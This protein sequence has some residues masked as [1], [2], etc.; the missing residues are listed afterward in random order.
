M[1]FKSKMLIILLVAFILIFSTTQCL[2]V[3]N[4]SIETISLTDDEISFINNILEENPNYRYYCVYISDDP[5]IRFV[6]FY[7]SYDDL[8]FYVLNVNASSPNSYYGIMCSDNDIDTFIYRLSDFTYV[9]SS[10]SYFETD[11][12]YYDVSSICHYAI[13]SNFDIYS[14]KTYAEVLFQAPPAQ[15]QGIVEKSLEE[16]EMK[17]TMKEILGI[18]PL[19]IVVVVSLVGLR[20]GLKMLSSLLH[21]A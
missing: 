5:S 4:I 8:K 9:K 21:K 18:L 16:V 14:D 11:I 19:I 17:A 6:R 10:R 15:K 2:A 3:S 7:S 13:F 20:K 12:T 1:K